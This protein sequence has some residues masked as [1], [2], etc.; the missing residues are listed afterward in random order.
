[1]RQEALTALRFTGASK[2]HDAKIIASLM[3]IA[4][5]KD[6]NL[7]RTALYTLGTRKLPPSVATKLEKLATHPE[8]E[9]ARFAIEQLGRQ[10]NNEA[11]K[12]LVGILCT[13]DR[14]RADLAAEALKG[15][16]DAIPLLAK[17]LMTIDDPDRAWMTQ[18]VLKPHAGKL[19]KTQR[20][21][22]LERAVDRLAGGKKG[23]EAPLQVVR[24]ASPD[25]AADGLREL[26]ARLLKAKK[27]DHAAMVARVLCRTD[28]A[29][30]K[31][32]Y[33]LATLEL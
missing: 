18:K 23:W 8:A 13:Q 9:R 27:T 3:K 28:Q 31:D 29:T 25:A 21:Q 5:G 7:A 16:K 2:T 19:T 20:T 22:L 14:S 32:R 12:A 26:A 33:H 1:M 17:A 30:N 4:E 11:I 15:K 6:T 24:D 10:D